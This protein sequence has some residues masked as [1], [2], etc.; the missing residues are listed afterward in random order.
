MFESLLNTRMPSLGVSTVLFAGFIWL[1]LT[2]LTWF[3]VGSLNFNFWVIN[4]ILISPPEVHTI[5][6]FK[7]G[8][9]DFQNAFRLIGKRNPTLSYEQINSFLGL[10]YSHATFFKL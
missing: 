7:E 3:M 2:V 10:D 1:S 8:T 4:D 9:L 6:K 5:L